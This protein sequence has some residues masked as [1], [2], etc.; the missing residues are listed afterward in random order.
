MNIYNNHTLVQKISINMN[1]LNSVQN[2]KDILNIKLRNL[3]NKCCELGY[4]KENSI[5]IKNISSGFLNPTIFVPFIEYKVNCDVDIFK[6]N[7]NDIYLV[8]VLSINK[9]GIMCYIKYTYGN[10]TFIPMKIIISKHTQDVNIIKNIKKGD[11]IYVKILG[12]KFSKNSNNIDSIANILSEEE[13]QNIKKLK[14]IINELINIEHNC[15]IEDTILN[16]YINILKFILDKTDITKNEL[17]VYHF[18][19][20]KKITILN[21]NFV[22]LYN[23]YINNFY[24]ITNK[25]EINIS[26]KIIEDDLSNIEIDNDTNCETNPE[27]ETI[28]EDN[29]YIKYNEEDDYSENDIA[30]NEAE[31]EESED[32]DD[33]DLDTEN[34]EDKNENDKTKKNLL[35]I[36][37]KIKKLN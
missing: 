10:K 8:D 24:N 17:F 35:K 29:D 31:E 19:N 28:E 37:N 6:P 22:D 23:D 27:D 13:I 26:N 4:I 30:E 2:I 11:K 34:L 20:K 14:L 3:E 25:N 36:E 21:M 16:K 18:I 12:F 5:K 33:D 1:E 9:I 32:D 15:N 7:V